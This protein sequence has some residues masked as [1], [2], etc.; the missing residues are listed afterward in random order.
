MAT[1]PIS[2]YGFEAFLSE[3]KLMGSTCGG[4]GATF[5]PPRP[6]C[7]EC[8]HTDMQWARMKGAGRLVALTS[9]S[10]G[11]PA[12]QFEGFNRKNPYCTGVVR[13][14][15][16]PRVVARI[17]GVDAQNPESIEIGIPVTA[18]Y[19]HRGE[20]EDRKT[21]LAFRPVSDDVTE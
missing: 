14:D 17:V 8:H 3:E 20:G 6:L 15:E 10:I 21:Q 16:G 2:D 9:I 12:M 5:V 1:Q 18:A 4:C 13:L 7:A 11:P 19:L